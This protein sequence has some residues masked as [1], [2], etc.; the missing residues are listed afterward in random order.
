MIVGVPAEVKTAENRVAITPDGVRELTAHGHRVVVQ[1]GAG[2][3]SSISD[4]DF[5]VAGATLVGVDEAWAAE[6]VVKVK[7]PQVDEYRRLQIG[8]GR[9]R[10]RRSAMPTSPWQGQRWSAWTRHG[11]PNWSS[12]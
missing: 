1:R 4:A 9:G 2:E 8:G 12:R 10:A 5:A 3:G 6:L 11:P 7:E